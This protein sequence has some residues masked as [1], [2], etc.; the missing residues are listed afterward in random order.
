[1]RGVR[2]ARR[3]VHE[4]RLVGRQR[5]LELHPGNRLVRHVGHE[6]VVRIA[7]DLDR[8][9][10]V[11][12]VR[13]PLVGLAAEEAVE[14]V[15]PG[16]RRPAVRGPGGADLPGR[17]LVV[18]AEEAGAVAVQPQHLGERRHVVRALPRVARERRGRLGD[19]A[20]VVHVVVAAAQQRRPRRRADRG[21]VELVVA[22]PAGG[23]TLDR[24]HVDGPAE[25][26]GH[27]EAHV[28]DEHDQHVGRAR[29]RLHLET[30]RR[31]RLPGI[32]FGFVRIV[33]LLDRQD[34]TVH[35]CGPARG[36]RNGR[37][38]GDEQ[39]AAN[40]SAPV[41]VTDVHV[42]D[43]IAALLLDYDDGC[44]RPSGSAP[45]GG[46]RKLRTIHAST[47]PPYGHRAEVGAM[48]DD[49]ARSLSVLVDLQSGE[50]AHSAAN[51]R[52]RVPSPLSHA[53]CPM[54]LM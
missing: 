10:T 31:R 27:A 19:P 44:R 7:R 42:F 3:E 25:P 54:P 1:M 41:A 6:V 23:Q 5:L 40:S 33:R 15:E 48:P 36:W 39:A 50:P 53:P 21:R 47:L 13:R 8:V 46:T 20:H 32:E 49:S 43:L 45:A 52:S 51:P 16:P 34:S 18:L 14:L 29:R 24:R 35:R 26:A 38:L 28:V 37:R 22:Q 12:E 30:R 9:H 4:E 11:V 2:G 17:G